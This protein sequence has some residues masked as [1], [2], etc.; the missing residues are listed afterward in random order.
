MSR[1]EHVR[2]SISLFNLVIQATEPPQRGEAS[3]GGYCHEH[4]VCVAEMLWVTRYGKA[5]DFWS[6][7]LA[8]WLA[9]QSDTEGVPVEK[10]NHTVLL[11][12]RGLVC[13]TFAREL[14]RL[15]RDCGW[16]VDVRATKDA[17]GPHIPGI[18]WLLVW[19]EV[20]AQR[21]CEMSPD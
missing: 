13:T 7:D 14:K 3:V 15:E 12:V 6:Y 1:G 11:R 4:T 16:M 18:V 9:L 17:V 8:Q 19:A 21:A 10:E 20:S 5:F 2:E